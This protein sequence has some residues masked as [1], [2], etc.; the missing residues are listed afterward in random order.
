M[1]KKE[2]GEGGRKGRSDQSKEEDRL[3]R[4]ESEKER[5][6]KVMEREGDGRG[7]WGDEEDWIYVQ[8]ALLGKWIY[9][10]LLGS[11]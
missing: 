11:W 2:G 9:E 7:L 5:C 10:T 1:N 6:R 3:K 4:Q 8:Y